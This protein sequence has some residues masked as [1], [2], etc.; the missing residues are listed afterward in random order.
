MANK[1]WFST[2]A[3][4]G[5]SIYANQ[6][7]AL[8]ESRA[9]SRSPNLLHRLLREWTKTMM[10]A[11]YPPVGTLR[12]TSVWNQL[13]IFISVKV[14]W[15]DFINL[16]DT[17]TRGKLLQ[18]NSDGLAN[19]VDMREYACCPSLGSLGYVDLTQASV[20]SKCLSHKGS[21]WLCFTRWN[22]VLRIS[23]LR[24]YEQSELPLT[25]TVLLAVKY[26][27]SSWLFVFSF[28]FISNTN[29]PICPRNMRMW[30]W[31]NHW[32]ITT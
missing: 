25:Q 8:Q 22:Q 26:T 17:P 28:R 6:C 5:N 18:W 9:V 32:L 20:C 27:S 2:P 11:L 14:P 24:C 29:L 19:Y 31:R 15:R 3:L 16:L 13:G 7:S 1:F 30:K 12:T 4:T 10:T 21:S 23:Y